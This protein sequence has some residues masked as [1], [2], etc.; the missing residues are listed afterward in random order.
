MALLELRAFA[1][2]KSLIDAEGTTIPEGVLA[3][4]VMEFKAEQGKRGRQES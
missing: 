1:N 4:L 3:D 2:V